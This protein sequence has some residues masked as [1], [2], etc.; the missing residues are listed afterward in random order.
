MIPP[1]IE[2]FLMEII[3]LAAERKLVHT[4]EIYSCHGHYSGW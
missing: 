3:H 2:R 1:V 4:G